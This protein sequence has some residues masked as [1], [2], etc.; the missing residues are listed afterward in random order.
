MAEQLFSDE[1]RDLN[2]H[3]Y[4][5]TPTDSSILSFHAQEVLFRFINGL[6]QAADVVIEGTDDID[7]TA[8]NDAS[9]LLASTNVA[10]GGVLEHEVASHHELFRVTV[11]ASGTIAA[12]SG[13]FE[14]RAIVQEP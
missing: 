5:A 1:I 8:F 11:T 2:P 10:A 12:T 14:G 3:S 13:A 4:I 9:E 7:G 6:D